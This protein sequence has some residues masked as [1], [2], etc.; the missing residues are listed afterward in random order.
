MIH[1]TTRQ[2]LVGAL[3]LLNSSVRCGWFTTIAEFVSQAGIICCI[4]GPEVP[5]V[6][7]R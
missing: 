3:Q 2:I 1:K 4:W 5:R 7:W 6:V